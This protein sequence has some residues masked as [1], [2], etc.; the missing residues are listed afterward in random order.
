MYIY[1]E[2]VIYTCS[3][4][5]YAYVHLYALFF[6]YSFLIQIAYEQFF[7]KTNANFNCPT[8][9]HLIYRIC[10]FYFFITDIYQSESWNEE[11]TFGYLH[12]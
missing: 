6:S 4:A 9:R 8:L 12:L 10:I 1:S 7:R 2:Q 11:P 5:E 3:S